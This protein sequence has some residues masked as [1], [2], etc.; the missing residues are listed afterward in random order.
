MGSAKK[1]L[2]RMR[3]C[4]VYV[5]NQ[6]M[7][8][9]WK[10]KA[11]DGIEGMRKAVRGRLFGAEVTQPQV[12]VPPNLQA[13]GSISIAIIQAAEAAPSV[14][15]SDPLK[16]WQNSSEIP[17]LERLL[18]PIQQEPLPSGRPSV[19]SNS[20]ATLPVITEADQYGR[21]H[22][23][24]KSH[25]GTSSVTDHLNRRS[26]ELFSS[27]TQHL[28][29]KR[30]GQRSRAVSLDTR[31]EGA[32]STIDL[33]TNAQPLEDSLVGAGDHLISINQPMISKTALKSQES[34]SNRD[35]GGIPTVSSWQRS[36]DSSTDKSGSTQSTSSPHDS[37]ELDFQ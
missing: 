18:P 23:S 16:R 35:C 34:L 20:R 2:V 8:S 37:P 4:F 14:G 22:S 31:E 3:P 33:N 19:E 12:D 36:L 29:K 27:V 26:P 9:K 13:E 25:S 7:K 6:N 21:S 1:S 10:R 24:P 11:V 15:V 30:T 5:A 17:V 32:S 28:R